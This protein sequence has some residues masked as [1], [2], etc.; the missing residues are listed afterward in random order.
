MCLS[1][2]VPT[3]VGTHLESL[4]LRAKRVDL[5]L[6]RWKDNRR[7]ALDAL[8]EVVGIEK[9]FARRTYISRK[10]KDITSRS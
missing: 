8:H 7:R 2:L 3:A 10:Q 9:A 1:S 6:V 4:D 5:C